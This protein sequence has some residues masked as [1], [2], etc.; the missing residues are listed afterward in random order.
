MKKKHTKLDFSTVSKAYS[1]LTTLAINL[2]VIIGGTFFLGNYLDTT[3]NT[4]PIFLFV[5]LILGLLACFRNLYILSMKSLPKEK[6]KYEYS[7]ELEDEFKDE[8]I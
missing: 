8:W 7:E 6:K 2:V 3:F 4:S 5:F 1:L